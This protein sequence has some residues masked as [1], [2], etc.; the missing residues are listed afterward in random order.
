MF[1][2][3]VFIICFKHM[4][5]QSQQ[6]HKFFCVFVYEIFTKLRARL[7]IFDLEILYSVG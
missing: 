1:I 6:S 7:Y 4:L 2:I 3:Y 5:S